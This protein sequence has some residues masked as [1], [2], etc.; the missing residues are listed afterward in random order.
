MSTLSMSQRVGMLLNVG[1]NPIYLKHRRARLRP[2]HMVSW[3]LITLTTVGFVFALVYF[4]V[5]ERGHVDPVEA[6]KAS[7]LPLIVVQGVLLMG[8]GTSAVATGIARE[9]DRELLDYQR[10][11]P[12]SP[13]AKIVGYLFGLPAREYFL[14]LLTLPFLFYAVTRSGLGWAKVG[15]FYVVFFS[16][17]W[18]YHMTGLMA[19]MVSKKPWQSSMISLG[20]VVGLYLVLPV[21]TS[22]VGL[23]FF[24]FLT[25]RPTFFAMIFEEINTTSHGWD[26]RRMMLVRLYREV[27]FFGMS[28]NPTVFSLVIQ[29]FGLVTMYHVVRRKWI[30][31]AWH[32]F[33]KRF[34]VGFVLG[35]TVL[36]AGS[37]WPMLR[38]EALLSDLVHRMN[39]DGRAYVSGV[40]IAV[41]PLVAGSAMLLCV[42]LVTP[43]HNTARRGLRRARRR[44]LHDVPAGWDAASS[45]RPTLVMLA[46]VW[47]GF[48]AVIYAAVNGGLVF[49][50]GPVP[51][52]W[53]LT[54]GALG[55]V[56]TLAF[57]AINAWLD[58]RVL[59]LALFFL[60]VVPVMVMVVLVSA[61]GMDTEAMYIGVTCPAVAGILTVLGLIDA[62]A[63]GQPGYTPLLIG[64]HP[65]IV[66]ALTIGFYG[67]LSAYAASAAAGKAKQRFDEELASESHRQGQAEPAPSPE[68]LPSPALT[69]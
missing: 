25:V 48:V 54:M 31:P 30:D 17:V 52:S 16:S 12:M 33:S 65:R 42:H 21:F 15:Q 46:F 39:V 18:L 45:T 51:W 29:C 34:A 57:Q 24:D 20:A 49:T 27:P 69:T 8:M 60:W 5:S 1:S 41:Y 62:T 28:L 66:I 38:S 56:T 59:V 26:V 63:S 44:G 6:A 53:L 35:I 47:A 36:V 37:L 9:R 55:T 2:R 13:A 11:T 4:T 50:T 43:S 40:L 32:P 64:D 19:G 14:F 67:V 23:S 3:G 61:F 22:W 58:Q 7:M 10:M 68:A